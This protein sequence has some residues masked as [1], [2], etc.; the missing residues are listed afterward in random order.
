MHKVNSAFYQK[1]KTSIPKRKRCFASPQPVTTISKPSPQEPFYVNEPRGNDK[2]I[3][4]H[5]TFPRSLKFPRT[6]A[7]NPKRSTVN[8]S[9][10]ESKSGSS[11]TSTSGGLPGPELSRPLRLFLAPSSIPTRRLANPL[12]LPSLYFLFPLSSPQIL[13]S[14]SSIA[15]LLVQPKAHHKKMRPRLG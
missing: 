7:T 8:V 5:E 2:N 3:R 12:P 14:T 4:P 10:S 13:A 15:G 6:T 1:K 11:R 9:I